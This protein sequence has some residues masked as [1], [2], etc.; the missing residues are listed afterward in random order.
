[1]VPRLEQLPWEADVDFF[2]QHLSR[3]TS[4]FVADLLVRQPM[5]RKPVRTAI[6]SPIF[7]RYRCPPACLLLSALVESLL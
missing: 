2:Q 5:A 1:M 3:E 6:H 7:A 4:S